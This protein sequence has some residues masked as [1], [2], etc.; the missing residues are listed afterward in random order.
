[1]KLFE[2]PVVE[3]INFTAENVLGPSISCNDDCP[4]ATPWM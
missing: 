3:V 1:M 2:M 4:D